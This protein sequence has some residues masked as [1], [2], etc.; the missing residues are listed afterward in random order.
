MALQVYLEQE[1]L[2]N[3][4]ANKIRFNY[5]NTGSLPSETTYEGMFAYDI[6]GNNLM[7]QTQVVG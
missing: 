3:K 7:L 1:Q 2:I 5:A 6:D 4:S